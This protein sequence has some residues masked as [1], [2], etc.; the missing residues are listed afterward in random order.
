MEQISHDNTPIY[1]WDIAQYMAHN[2][3]LL[4]IEASD[5]NPIYIMVQN[6]IE[7]K[8]YNALNA[9]IDSKEW[10]EIKGRK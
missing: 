2:F 8:I 1:Y 7:N 5:N 9:F 6:E 3:E 4:H 10:L